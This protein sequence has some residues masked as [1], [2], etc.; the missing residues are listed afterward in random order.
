LQENWLGVFRLTGATL[1]RFRTSL[2][3]LPP[4]PDGQVWHR[5]VY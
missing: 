3:E 2:R 1:S 5:E 4:R